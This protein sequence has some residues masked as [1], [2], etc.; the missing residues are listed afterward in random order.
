MTIVIRT[1]DVNEWHVDVLQGRGSR[2]ARRGGSPSG[3]H[4]GFPVRKLGAGGRQ[5]KG[6]RV[7]RTQ[8]VETYAS[9]DR[10]HGNVVPQGE[11][12]VLG[13]PYPIGE[14]EV[15]AGPEPGLADPNAPRANRT[16]TVSGVEDVILV[17]DGAAAGDG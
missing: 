3:H 7:R 13:V 4:A 16:Y 8:Q 6:R 17:E 9:L 5:D 10:D 1:V 14:V 2:S 12:A 11:L 15:L